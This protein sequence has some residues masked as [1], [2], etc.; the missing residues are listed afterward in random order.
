MSMEWFNRVTGE[1]QDHLN[2][3]CEEYDKVG[4]LTIDQSAKHPRVEFFV[5]T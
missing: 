4:Q 3:I 5:E 1:L 2:S